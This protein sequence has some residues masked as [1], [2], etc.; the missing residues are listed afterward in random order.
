MFDKVLFPVIMNEYTEQ[1]ISCLGGL[2]RNGTKEVLL[3]HVL[4]VTEIAKGNVSQEQDENLLKKWKAELEDSGIRSDFKIIK[5]IPWLEIVELADRS[6]YSFVMLGSHGNT[7]LDKVFLGSVTENV[8]HHTKKPVFIFKLKK[9]LEAEHVRYCVDVFRKVLYVTDFSAHSSACIPYI[10]Q[11]KNKLYQEL[12][13]LHVQDIR[14]LRHAG[15][16]KVVEYQV[17][18]SDQMEELKKRFEAVGF[19]KV[20][21]EVRSGYAMTEILN[22]AKET[23]SSIIVLGKKG[24]SDVREM[25]LGGVAET[26]IHKSEVPVFLIG[27]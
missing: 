14:E 18:A 13:I 6:D 24:N 15:E 19:E 8:V 16:K 5:G 20:V 12:H 11:M 7:F 27:N 23:G 9:D 4:S 2:S 1:I 21:T 3:F 17:A 10:E 25:L 22:Y 26:V